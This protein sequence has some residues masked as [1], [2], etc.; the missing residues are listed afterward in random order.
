M[1]I[2]ALVSPDQKNAA[3]VPGMA[4]DCENASG[5]KGDGIARY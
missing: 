3:Q 2:R 4:G 5:F 1:V